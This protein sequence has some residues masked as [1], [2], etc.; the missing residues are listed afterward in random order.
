MYQ[1]QPPPPPPPQQQQQQFYHHHQSGS[2]SMVAPPPYHRPSSSF[3]INGNTSNQPPQPQ[4]H[5][6]T[7]PPPP[8]NAYYPQPLR[9]SRS[10]YN[11]NT[12][13]NPIPHPF[14]SGFI[15]PP[16][17][18]QQPLHQHHQSIIASMASAPPYM[19]SPPL[20]LKMQDV[21]APAAVQV[22]APVQD[23][24]VNGG[25]NSVLEYDLN[26]MAA[27]LSWCSFGMLK[28]DKNP[29]KDFESLIVSVLFATRLP[30]S[31]II[32]ALEYMNQRFSNVN[33]N[34]SNV[35]SSVGDLTEHQIFIQ[36]IVSLI[37]AN[38]FNDDNTFTNKS[39]HGATGLKLELLNK[40]EKDWLDE[41]KW[42]LNVVNFESNIVTLQECWI[43]WLDKYG[44]KHK[45]KDLITSSPPPISQIQQ[46]QVQHHQHFNSL[47]SKNSFS[48]IPSSPIYSDH[49]NHYYYPSSSSPSITPPTKYSDGNS[50]WFDQQQGVQPQPQQQINNQSIWN[51]FNNTTPSIAFQPNVQMQPPSQ[52]H[53]HS[54]SGHFQPPPLM[55]LPLP[56]NPSTSNSS[57]PFHHNPILN[58]GGFVGYANPYYMASC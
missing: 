27:F 31:T 58:H 38:K 52:Q 49:P 10:F 7:P 36:L 50:L 11:T 57:Y 30:K 12:N 15:P 26:T 4:T 16:P 34:N 33:N 2:I 46:V 8:P 55:A 20:M 19:S 35:S 21:P 42:S 37:L 5:Y 39:W 23:E 13:T 48:S 29:T 9:H 53:Q 17:Q 47:S 22:P 45:I 43:T 51:N 40:E 24:Q 41:C 18:Q 28:Q 14:N 56:S 32:I 54:Q 1:I 6:S 3:G 44:D 25:I